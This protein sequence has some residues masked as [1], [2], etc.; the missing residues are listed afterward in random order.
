MV[1]P[2][3]TSRPL[4]AALL[5]ASFF[6]QLACQAPE[7]A[8]EPPPANPLY[9]DSADFDFSDNPKLLT[10]LHAS[11][12]RYFRFINVP[13]SQEICRRF[14]TEIAAAPS[15]NLHGD[16]H[17]EQYAVTS[18]GRGMTDFDDSSIGPALVDVSRFAVS[19]RLA[20][21]QEGC[22]NEWEA[23]FDDF[24]RGYRTAL[25]DP[26]AEVPV[27]R[28][29]VRKRDKFK[30][31]R[32][33]FLGFVE[34]AMEPVPEDE[35][36]G[37]REALEPYIGA[38]LEEHP[39]LDADFFTVEKLGYLRA[40]VG[41]A[42]DL[43]FLVRIR[44]PSTEPLDDVVLEVK[45]VRDLTGIPCIAVTPGADPLRVLHG[46]LHIANQPYRYLGYARFRG[47]NFWV[48]AWEDNYSELEIDEDFESLEEIAEIVFDVGVQLGRGHT[49]QAA[50]QL[51]KQLR[52]EQA[53]QI[54]RDAEKIKAASQEL[55]RLTLEAWER[56]KAGA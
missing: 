4:I 22:G 45:Q 56:F 44:G 39:D 32:Q 8:E 21:E 11:P 40:G 6:V 36:Q 3:S 47:R 29:A 20:C 13:F 43:K 7:K 50:A 19:L 48:H 51:E 27:P 25:E 16:A 15:F 42:L 26:A 41:S 46:H 9:V 49:R 17:V 1:R 2:E 37:L 52:R 5:A 34:S 35:A 33:G 53:E 38:M 31:D 54:D 12:H 30:A 55:A 10:K 23:L 28:L 24:L 18:E 14:E